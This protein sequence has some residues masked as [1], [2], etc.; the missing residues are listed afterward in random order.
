MKI[1]IGVH[2]RYHAF[3]LAREL[4]VFNYRVKLLTTYPKFLT[5]KFISSD[6][7]LQAI[8]SLE[9]L[10]RVSQR[11]GF[12]SD[13][14]LV[15][16]FGKF[17]AK[18][19][20]DSEIIFG[21][22][23]A[24][25]EAIEIAHQNGS[26]FILER[27]SSHIITQNNILDNEYRRWGIKWD[28]IEPEIISRE[29]EEYSKADIITVG[30][31]YSANTFINKGIDA[32]KI[33][34]NQYG[35]NLDAFRIG[36]KIQGNIVPRIMF[37]GTVG[38]RKGIQVLLEAFNKIKPR[39]ELHI[40]GNLEPSIKSIIKKYKNNNIIIRGPIPS[41]LMPEEFSKA[42][43]F[44]LPSIEEGFGMV[45]LQAMA[46][47]T[48]VIASDVTGGLEVIDNGQNGM[49][50]PAGDSDK[51]AEALDFLLTYPAIRQ[52]MGEAARQKTLKGW[53]WSNYGQRA[54]RLIDMIAN[55]K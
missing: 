34:I 31:S 22:S 27:G 48:P 4:S 5:K 36:R 13:P 23:S 18:N 39:A 44:C 11:L 2:G 50:V 38:I 10:R 37:A 53:D 32:R 9:V 19:I 21:W 42:D 43:I 8:P 46:A 24:S 3:D 16:E 20:Y 28:G 41:L 7:D 29:I 14:L 35:V 26:K 12:N 30:S 52:K 47:C 17:F 15:R 33:Y 40:I 49:L 45:I 51:L 6:I 1:S 55:T 54:N 25:L